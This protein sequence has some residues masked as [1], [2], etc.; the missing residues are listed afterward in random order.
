MIE[1]LDVRIEDGQRVLYTAT[2]HRLDCG[3]IVVTEVRQPLT[4]L[5]DV[6]T[7]LGITQADLDAIPD[8]DL[9]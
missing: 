7:E 8:D 9:T 3:A 5:D 1:P 6:M 4:S 2:R